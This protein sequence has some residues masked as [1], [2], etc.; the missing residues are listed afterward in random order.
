MLLIPTVVSPSVNEDTKEYTN[1]QRFARGRRTEAGGGA[2]A[3]RAL[4]PDGFF[5]SAILGGGSLNELR[6]ACAVAEQEREGGVSPRTSPMAQGAPRAPR[7][8]PP[9]RHPPLPLPPPPF[10]S[11]SDSRV[12]LTGFHVFSSPLPRSTHRQQLPRPACWAS[13]PLAR[14]RGPPP[15]LPVRY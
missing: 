4:R 8:V 13:L 10:L 2:Q 9:S 11:C 14:G 15:C 5:L 6:I 7:R 3:R 1:C 12:G